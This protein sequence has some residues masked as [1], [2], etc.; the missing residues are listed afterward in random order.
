MTSR[1]KELIDDVFYDFFRK[2]KIKYDCDLLS[3]KLA[4]ELVYYSADKYQICFYRSL[5]DG[6]VNCLLSLGLAA[7]Y[8]FHP[9]KWLFVRGLAITKKITIEGLI[10][11]TSF[12]FLSD[13]DELTE[14]RNILDANYIV[15][16]KNLTR[17]DNNS[18]TK[19]E[20]RK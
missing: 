8:D 4:K 16:H 19:P 3:D 14:I 10:N 7:D 6:E 15:I 9:E 5:R 12:S 17:K 20:T 18:T 11:D 1:F 13:R 2:Y